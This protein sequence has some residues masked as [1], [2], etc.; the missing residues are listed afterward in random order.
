MRSQVVREDGSRRPLS[1]VS[2]I[3]AYLY[4]MNADTSSTATHTIPVVVNTAFTD[5]YTTSDAGWTKD[6]TGYNFTW[7]ASGEYFDRGESL[8]RLE[9]GIGCESADN[10]QHDDITWVV[11]AVRTKGLLSR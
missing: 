1:E 7:T 10:V 11:V 6:T 8:Y 4:D 3:T 9:I 2:W 5:S